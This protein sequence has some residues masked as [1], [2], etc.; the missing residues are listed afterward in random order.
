MQDACE[1][2]IDIPLPPNSSPTEFE[3]AW[4]A[5]L[6]AQGLTALAVPPAQALAARFRLCGVTPDALR[7][8]LPLRLAAL[9][10]APAVQAEADNSPG[11]WQGVRV[12]LSYPARDLPALLKRPKP[13]FHPARGR[14]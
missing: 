6:S 12:W 3:R 13:Q 8:Y 5:A 4:R 14:R 7:H 11:D 9:P 1:L 10:G 2:R